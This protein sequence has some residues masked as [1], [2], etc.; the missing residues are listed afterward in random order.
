[1]D[2]T[3]EPK[4]DVT[5]VKASGDIN[6]ASC[7]QLEETLTGLIDQGRTR[8][9]LVSGEPGIG[10]TRL[11]GELATLVQADG[12]AVAWGRCHDD[13]GAPPLWP[14]VQVLRGFLASGETVLDHLR[15]L[16]A[17]LLPGMEAPPHAMLLGKDETD[18]YR[19]SFRPQSGG[20]PNPT[21]EGAG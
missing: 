19:G 16:L 3:I 9:V 7:G 13:E 6:A 8:M 12:V 20:I 2:L 21:R 15:P 1:M 17:P 14:W 11:M 18:Y 5:V 4:G 10:K